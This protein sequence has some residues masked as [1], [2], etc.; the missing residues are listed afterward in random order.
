LIF[1]AT[2]SLYSPPLVR[3]EDIKKRS[4]AP[5]KHQASPYPRFG[6]VEGISK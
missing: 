5:L 3:G 4:F 1:L 6:F 2:L